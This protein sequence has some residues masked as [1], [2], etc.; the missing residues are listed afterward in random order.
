MEDI[1]RQLGR[2]KGRCVI[3][4]VQ[5]QPPN[6]ALEQ[7]RARAGEMA[8][9]M[10]SSGCYVCRAPREVCNRWVRDDRAVGRIKQRAHVE[11]CDY[12]GVM[13]GAVV[14]IAYAVDEVGDEWLQRLEGQEG[15]V[16]VREGQ[17]KEL[18][19]YL[20]KAREMDGCESNNLTWEFW[21]ITRRVEGYIGGRGQIDD[22]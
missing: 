20:K 6:H 3:C 1:R 8:H 14:G 9:E 5:G 17:V 13:L 12:E 2:W 15:V 21:W 11:R 16:G 22:R 7:C 18:A 4:E 10:R 19:G